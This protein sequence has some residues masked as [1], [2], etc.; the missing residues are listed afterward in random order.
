VNFLASLWKSISF[1]KEEHEMEF[2][3]ADYGLNRKSIR[4]VLAHFQNCKDCAAEDSILIATQDDK[5]NDV[6][7]LTPG[8]FKILSDNPE[9]DDE[10]WEDIDESYFAG[11]APEAEVLPVFVEEKNDDRVME[12][13]KVWVKKVIA[14]FNVCPFTMDPNKAGIPMGNVRY[15]L[16]RAKTAEEAF[17][18][19]WEEVSS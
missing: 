8:N 4:G 2:R 14:D 18:R 15:N 5:K 7:V 19:Y 10:I 11:D 17:Y 13:I 1:P 6:L 12:I 9:D 3:L 16:S